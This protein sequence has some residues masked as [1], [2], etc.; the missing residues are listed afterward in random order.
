MIFD[1]VLG[2]TQVETNLY[3]PKVDLSSK[4]FTLI[5]SEIKLL[6]GKRNFIDAS[7]FSFISGMN[8]KAIN[9]EGLLDRILPHKINTVGKLND[10]ERTGQHSFEIDLLFKG[11]NFAVGHDNNSLSGSSLEQFLEN[12]EIAKMKKIW[13]DVKNLSEKKLQ[14][15]N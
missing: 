7:N 1:L 11:D 12:V 15:C 14:R 9:N 4:Y 5:E 6:N 10:L 2:I 13:L 8:I 3:N